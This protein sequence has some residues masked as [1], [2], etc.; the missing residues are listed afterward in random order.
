[1]FLN[2][3]AIA[4]R[5]E[6]RITEQMTDL[7]IEWL[8]GDIVIT[9]GTSD[10]IVVMQEGSDKFPEDK[11]FQSQISAGR[12][13]ITDGRKLKR[14]IGLNIQKTALFVYLP[15]RL[16]NS[17][18]ISCTG[19]KLKVQDVNA[20]ILKCSMTSGHIFMSGTLG[21]L[22]LHGTAT[23]VTGEDLLVDRMNLKLTSASVRLAGQFGDINSNSTGSGVHLDSSIAP[24]RIRS[25]STA[26][27]VTICLPESDGFQC[28]I[29][30]VS[31]SFNSDFPLVS[32]GNRF[33]YKNGG[34][35]YEAE[36][37]GGSFSLRKK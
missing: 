36:V 37:R 32:L 12:L 1:M 26:N 3:S 29:K 2:N 19:G 24:R 13:L 28:S 5:R 20:A 34:A 11:L 25:V 21:E 10:H 7:F 23:N 18:T 33:V 31:G 8:T 4:I 35:V 9:Q 6:Q 17:V 30:K 15:D 22:S 14:R 27:R 16:L